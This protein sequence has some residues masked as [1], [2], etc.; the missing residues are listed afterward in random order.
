M[1][2]AATAWNIHVTS[3]LVVKICGEMARKVS[4][5]TQPELEHKTTTFLCQKR[6]ARS[7]VQSKVESQ[8][9]AWAVGRSVK[10][11]VGNDWHTSFYS[12]LSTLPLDFAFHSGK[13]KS[14][15]FSFIIWPF[16][17]LTQFSFFR[18]LVVRHDV[19]T[20][21]DLFHYINGKFPCRNSSIFISKIIV[22]KS[23]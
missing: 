12:F 8:W 18:C 4:T 11:C 19:S 6:R 22:L 2:K 15:F 23:R 13:G 21:H 16:S 20:S 17:S 7:P 1:I 9:K 3:F 14:S 10:G 5:E